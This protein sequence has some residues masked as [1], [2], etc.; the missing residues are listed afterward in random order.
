MDTPSAYYSL[1]REVNPG[2]SNYY[3]QGAEYQA[4]LVALADK[5]RLREH[6]RFETE[7]EA[8]WWDEEQQHWQI[9]SVSADGTREISHATVVVTAAGY[10]N[11]PPRWPDL[12]G[13][14]TFA[15]TS[16]HSAL[17]DPSSTSLVSGWRSSAPVAPPCRSSTPASISRAPHGVPAPAP[18]GSTAKA[19]D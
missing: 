6:T 14:D 11:R 18:L 4:Y 5:H 13:R 10:L 16:V 17:W 19:T 1:S 15:G 8:L 9:H 3:P 2:W 7:V 12:P